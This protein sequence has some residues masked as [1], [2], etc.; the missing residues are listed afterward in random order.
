MTSLWTLRTIFIVKPV[1]LLLVTKS[2]L[3]DKGLV[4]RSSGAARD[5]ERT[6]LQMKPAQKMESRGSER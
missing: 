1:F 5:I 2:I 6:F 3:T 4:E